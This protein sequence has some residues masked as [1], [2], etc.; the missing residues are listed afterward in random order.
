MTAAH[1]VDGGADPESF[2]VLAGAHNKLTEGE[3][4]DV[5][6]IYIHPKY[7]SEASISSDIALLKLSGEHMYPASSC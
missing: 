4:I 2:K 7:A 6:R 1:C 5:E 3:T